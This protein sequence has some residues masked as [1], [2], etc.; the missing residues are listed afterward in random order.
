MTS[1]DWRFDEAR[2]C[3]QQDPELWFAPAADRYAEPM[4]R[5]RRRPGWAAQLC[6]ECPIATKDACLAWAIEAREQ[7]GV[8]GGMTADERFALIQGGVDVA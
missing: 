7:H 5:A 6:A 4:K 2:P 8:W 1:E 3:G